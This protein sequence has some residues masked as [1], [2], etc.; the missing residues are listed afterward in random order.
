MALTPK[1]VKLNQV[2]F[3]SALAPEKWSIIQENTLASTSLNHLTNLPDQHFS[4]S[5]VLSQDDICVKHHGERLRAFKQTL[6]KTSCEDAVE[7]LVMIDAIQRLGIE[8]N[9]QEEID[10]ILKRQYLIPT[11]N[12]YDLHETALRFRLLRQ[13]GYHVLPGVFNNFKDEGKFKKELTDDIKGLMGLYEASQLSIVGEDILDEAADYSHRLL[14]SSTTHLDDTQARIV[15]NTLQYPHHKSLSRFMAKSFIRDFQRPNGWMNEL[16]ELAKID[17]KMVQSQ[18]QQ[19]ILK[20]S[21]WWKEVGLSKE[22]K[23]ARNQPLKWYMCSMETLADPSLSEQRVDLTKPISFIFLIDDIFD[24]YGTLDELILFTDVINRW[25]IAAAEQLPDYMR[26]CFMALDNITDEISHKVYKQLGW[27]PVDSLRKTWASLCN[28]FL[29]EA[30]WFGSGQLPNAEEYLK[31]GIISSGVHVVLV[32]IF[33]LLG[34][35]VTKE[36]VE[37]IDNHPPIISSTAAILRL[38]D[39]L[40]S[41]KD[42]DQDGHDGSYVECYMKE[43]K[44]CSVESV[45]KKVNDMISN[46]WKQLNQE[47]LSP[48]PFSSTFNKAC[49]NLARM[50]PLM[51]GYDD[52]QNLPLLESHVK[53]IL[54]DNFS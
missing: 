24:V 23:F 43:Y 27:N 18:H 11:T 44:G 3:N 6:A 51:Y 40:G 37:L 46:A 20:I 4:N 45:R 54:P 5:K 29:V 26:I 28:A 17:M 47:C 21:R 19:E 22:L 53:S 31:N 2:D 14:N 13:E 1:I 48:T 9:F 16:Q 38:W 8:Y 35:G 41:A 25:D 33:F 7:G 32:H 15:K 39:D 12:D 50:V 10:A 49:L 34:H 36:N 52:C 42:E 30:K